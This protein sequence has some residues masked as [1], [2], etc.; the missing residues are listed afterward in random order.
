MIISRTDWFHE[1]KWGVFMHFLATP[2]SSSQGAET[3]ADAWNRRVDSFDVKGVAKQLIEARAKYFVLTLGQNSG[4]YCCPNEAYDRLTG[5]RPSKCARRDLVSELHDALAPHGIRLMVY[6]PAGA[7][8]YEPMA[9]E[10]MKWAKGGR[11][12]EFQRN[13]ES[14][15]R[16]WSLRWG[17]KVSGW[18]FDGCYYDDEMYRHADEPNFKSFAAAV[19]AGN[20]DSIV[21]WD[22]GVQYPPYTVDAE[23]DYTAGEVNE[24]QEVDAPGR[25][26]K[27]AQFH[28]LTFLG[29]YWAQLPIRFTASEAISHTLSFTDCG[30]VVTWDVPLTYEGLIN[31]EAFA[32]LK[33]VG[34]AVDA[35]RGNPDRQPLKVVRPSISFLKVP[36][37]C[38]TGKSDG[39]LRLTLKN[40]W[41]EQ[42]SGDVEI[43][44]EPAS[45]ARIEGTQRIAYDLM[46]GAESR[47]DLAFTLGENASADTAAKIVLTRSGDGRKLVYRL[48]K[49]ESC[50]LPRLT[51]LPSLAELADA[52]KA[53]PSRMITTDEGRGL[54]DVKLA[55][56]DG[57]LAVFCRAGDQIMRQAPGIWDG[58]C[59]ELFGIAEPGDRI[60]QIFFVPAT[61]DLP[62]K[63]LKLIPAEHHSKINIVPAPELKFASWPVPG[64]YTSAA[65]IPLAWWLNR[66]APPEHFFFEIIV[67]TG[68]DMNSFGRAAMFGSINASSQSESYAI[69]RKS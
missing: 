59:L 7:P 68:V 25:W 1:A 22:P 38:G 26:D 3:D 5:I 54:A 19:R 60:N 29:K 50:M 41:E 51:G 37:V 39:R 28:I 52:M 45:F 13:W 34:K 2:A 67:N 10:K 32:I 42:I 36:S 12:A 16:E 46:P 24:P 43:A 64:G 6:L 49:R 8:E 14:V 53:V 18:W 30:G 23:E 35:T 4:H 56:A 62:A 57:H 47:T 40:R 61:A 17:R 48:P 15:I 31:P 9:V 66:S 11:C 20:P 63:A 55:I 21:A 33:E 27:H 65:L 44:V 69:C 58:S